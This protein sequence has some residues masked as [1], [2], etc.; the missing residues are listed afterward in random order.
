MPSTNR[1]LVEQPGDERRLSGSAGRQIANT[2]H[3]HRRA[4][5]GG[6]MPAKLA[7]KPPDRCQRGSDLG[8]PLAAPADWCRRRSGPFFHHLPGVTR[9]SRSKQTCPLLLLPPPLLLCFAWI[10]ASSKGVVRSRF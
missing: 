7:G 10:T 6:E 5:R 2:D 3:R 8:T 1:Q 4:V 9:G